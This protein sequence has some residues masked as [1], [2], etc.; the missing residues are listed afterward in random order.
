ME[1]GIHGRSGSSL[2]TY[3]EKK[4]RLHNRAKQLKC[5]EEK[6]RFFPAVSY[7]NSDYSNSAWHWGKWLVNRNFMLNLM[8]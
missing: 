5:K 7:N 6:K 3:P 1:T 4:F 2:V 8:G